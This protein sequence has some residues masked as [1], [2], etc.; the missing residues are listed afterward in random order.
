[1]AYL[2]VVESLIWQFSYLPIVLKTGRVPSKIKAKE[3][4]VYRRPGFDM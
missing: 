4:K 2:P 3:Y 1:M